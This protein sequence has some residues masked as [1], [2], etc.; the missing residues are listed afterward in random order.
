MGERSAAMIRYYDFDQ[1]TT[2]G[3]DGSATGTATSDH[4]L[5]GNV[6]ALYINYSAAQ[7]ATSD[8]T[9]ASGSPSMPILTRSNS[10][11]DGWFFPRAATCDI[12]ATASTF[13]GTRPVNDKIPV[14]DYVTVS[15]AQADDTETV[16]VRIVYED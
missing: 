15:V 1:I 4:P 16:D 13:D 6:L 10:A 3:V 14:H 2:S 11:T 8:V 12:T 9:I 5:V 7:A